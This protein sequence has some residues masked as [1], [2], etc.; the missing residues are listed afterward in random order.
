M[1]PWCGM[2]YVASPIRGWQKGREVRL[3]IGVRDYVR[4]RG[5]EGSQKNGT[6]RRGHTHVKGCPVTLGPRRA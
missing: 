4:E 5:E 1:I 6:S 3:Y 2:V